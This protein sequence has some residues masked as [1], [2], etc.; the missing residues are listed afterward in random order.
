MGA[1][2]SQCL[3]ASAGGRD[4]G[5]RGRTYGGRRRAGHTASGRGGSGSRQCGAERGGGR[6]HGERLEGGLHPLCVRQHAGP[7]SPGSGRGGRG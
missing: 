6:G 4:T 5:Q 7:R 2:A 3:V 1:D